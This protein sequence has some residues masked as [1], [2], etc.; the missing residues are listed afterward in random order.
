MATPPCIGAARDQMIG[1]RKGARG[2]DKE[3]GFPEE[4]GV[5]GGPRVNGGWHRGVRAR[6]LPP[7]LEV[8]VGGER[9]PVFSTVGMR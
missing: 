5:P 6:A 2:T 3:E 4:L 9:N 8:V 1:R 7:F